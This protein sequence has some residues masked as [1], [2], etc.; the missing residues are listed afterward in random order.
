M[1]SN[2]LNLS[3]DSIKKI[4]KNIQN[5][6]GEKVI[7]KFIHEL[8]EY[9][10]KLQ[11]STLVQNLPKDIILAF[12]KYDGNFAQCFDYN[13]KKIYYISKDNIVGPKPEVGE[14]LKWYSPGKYYVDYTGIPAQES[15]IDDY[16]QECTIA[17]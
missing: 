17:K 9:L 4:D 2:F 3:K 5:K 1:L 13:N 6:K 15:K 16:L 12:A 11:S 14:T 7:D 10:I 8:Q